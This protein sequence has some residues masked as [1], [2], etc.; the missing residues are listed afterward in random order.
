MVELKITTTT[1]DDLR[2]ALQHLV[3]FE[4]TTFTA[5]GIVPVP[6]G[7]TEDELRRRFERWNVPGVTIERVKE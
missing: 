3:G 6:E 4:P 2:H 1:L 7:L 5:R